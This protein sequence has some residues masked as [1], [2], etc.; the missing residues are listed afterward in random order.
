[1]LLVGIDIETNINEDEFSNITEIGV[2][3]WDTVRELPI[4]FDNFLIDEADRKPQSDEAVELTGIDDD[5]LDE[6]GWNMCENSIQLLATLNSYFKMADYIVAHNGNAFDKPQLKHFYDKYDATFETP[7]WI[8]TMLDVEYPPSC[9]NK[10]LLYLAAYQ[11]FINP[12]AHRAVFDALA[13]LRILSCYDI[14]RVIE[15]AKSPQI[16]IKAHVSYDQRQL[17]KDARFHWDADSKSW[18][19]DIK[20]ILLKD[21]EFPFTYTRIN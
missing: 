8:D 13:M 19:L 14:H 15:V 17:A 4:R 9:T 7:V 10:N 11:G 1:M 6:Y 18:L 5:M 3:L 2:V 21:K 16:T 12:F 20:E